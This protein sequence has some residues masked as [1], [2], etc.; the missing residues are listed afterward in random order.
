MHNFSVRPLYHYFTNVV[1]ATFIYTSASDNNM[2]I[3]IK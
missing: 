3:N 2:K 1:I